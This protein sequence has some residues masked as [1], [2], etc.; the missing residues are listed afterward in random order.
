MTSIAKPKFKCNIYPKGRYTDK[1]TGLK[2][3]VMQFIEGFKKIRVQN[4]SKITVVFHVDVAEKY[5][6]EIT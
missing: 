4:S 5:F 1:R 6:T 3:T 2:Y